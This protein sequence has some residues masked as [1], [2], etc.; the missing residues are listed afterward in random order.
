M[1]KLF[2]GL[3]I[4]VLAGCARPYGSAD[5]ILDQE[6]VTPKNDTE[7]TKVKITRNTQF[8]GIAS[9]GMCRFVISIDDKDV[10]LLRQNQFVTAYL[11]NGLHK[12]RVRN[13]CNI[14]TLGMRKSLDILVD[15]TPQEYMTEVGAWGQ[16]RMWQVK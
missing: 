7:H 2:L 15:G 1:K 4:V 6:V 10:A 11:T 5:I 3:A 13:D 16:Y 14:A 8:I 9:G 12:L